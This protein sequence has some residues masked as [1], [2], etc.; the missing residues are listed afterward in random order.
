MAERTYDYGNNLPEKASPSKPETAAR[1]DSYSVLQI[2]VTE[3]QDAIKERAKL[4]YDTEQRLKAY[5]QNIAKLREHV[6]LQKDEHDRY[7]KLLM[8]DVAVAMGEA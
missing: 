1:N 5:D 3:L 4:E 6:V 7:L 2:A 8:E